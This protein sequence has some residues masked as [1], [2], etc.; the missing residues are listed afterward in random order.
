LLK[1]V[2]DAGYV[3]LFALKLPLLFTALK[4]VAVW[5]LKEVNDDQGAYEGQ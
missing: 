4:L 2:Q 3:P 5:C 1:D